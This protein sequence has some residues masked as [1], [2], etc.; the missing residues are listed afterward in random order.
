M[1]GEEETILVKDM[2]SLCQFGRI[3]LSISP[4]SCL[5]RFSQDVL[6]HCLKMTDN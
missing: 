6:R 1:A 3:K 2:L 5:A 4:F